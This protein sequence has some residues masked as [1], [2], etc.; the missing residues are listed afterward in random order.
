[1]ARGHIKYWS[2]PTLTRL[3][4]ENGFAVRRFHGVGRLPYLWK[5]MILVAQKV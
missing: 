4:H 3:M 1:M 2:R 5:S